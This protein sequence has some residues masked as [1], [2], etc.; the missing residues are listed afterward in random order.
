MLAMGINFKTAPVSIRE[1]VSFA[2]NELSQALLKLSFYE[3]IG[4]VILVSTCNRTEFYVITP[5]LEIAQN[6][7]ARFLE[8]EKN[9]S[10][11]SLREH[12]YIY[13]N[14]FAAEHLYRV[15]GGIDSLILG[16]GEILAQIKH[17]FSRAMEVGT[18]GKIFNALFRFALESG[19]K[20]RTET[21]ISKRP[22]STGSVVSKLARNIFPDLESRTALLI[23][24]GKISEITAKNLKAHNI[25]ELIIV[26]RTLEKAVKLADELEGTAYPYDQLHKVINQADIVIVCVG[27]NEY[28]LHSENYKPSKETLVVDLSMPRNVCP[29]LSKNELINIY[30][31]DSLETVAT[32]NRE[33]R[34]EIIQEVEMIIAEEMNKFLE[35]FNALDVSPVISSLSGLF[36][37]IREN[38]ISKAVKKYKLDSEDKKI[39]DIVT[40]SIVQKIT[41]YPVTNLK[42]TEDKSMKKRYIEDINYLFQLNTDDVHQKYFRKKPVITQ[43]ITHESNCPVTALDTPISETKVLCPFAKMKS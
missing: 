9:V 1:S 24:A 22:T 40:R 28:I 39:I 16:E 25:G 10:Y 14:K 34:Y 37:E 32:M 2:E 21:S 12:F 19:K 5:D 15:T 6:S 33:E 3:G 29:S 11:Y 30:D 38:E 13:Y 42:M 17:S 8:K 26:N 31:I 18:S 27:V 4:E 43:K 7:I 20:V 35:W 23:G 41:H 36:E